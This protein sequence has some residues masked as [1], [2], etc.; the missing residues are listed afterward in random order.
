MKNLYQI[1]F[2]VLEK[3]CDA[4]KQA[5]FVEGTGSFGHFQKC[6]WHTWPRT[7]QTYQ[8]E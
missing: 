1:T 3:N 7:I 6:S 4:V 8:R 5:M 2:Y